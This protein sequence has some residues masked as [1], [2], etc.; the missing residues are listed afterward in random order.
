MKP[1]SRVTAPNG[2]RMHIA[3]DAASL[4]AAVDFYQTLFG[5]PPT[6]RRADYAKFD[7]AAPALNLAINEAPNASAGR[8]RVSHFGIELDSPA[9]VDAAALKL[10]AAGLDVRREDDVT[11]CYARQHRAWV[12]DPDGHAWEL[13]AVLDADMPERADALGEQC[14]EPTCCAP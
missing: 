7:M 1:S 3:I 14:C 6:K 9:E 2:G 12:H 11:C 8:G 13:F 5:V 4:E 10:E